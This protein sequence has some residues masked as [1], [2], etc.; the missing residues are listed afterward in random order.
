MVTQQKPSKRKKKK[1]KPKQN[2]NWIFFFNPET[3]GQ[4]HSIYELDVSPLFVM[5]KY[6]RVN[7]HFLTICMVNTFAS[8][9]WCR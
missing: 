8:C 3:E 4:F 2:K 6:L 1:K 5:S 9:A 7:H